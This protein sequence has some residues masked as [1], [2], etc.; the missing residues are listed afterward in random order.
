[1]KKIVCRYR[2]S[3]HSLTLENLVKIGCLKVTEVHSLLTNYKKV[4]Y[5]N[6]K[7]HY[8]GISSVTEGRKRDNFIIN[9]SNHESNIY[10]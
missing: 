2:V 4:Q 6:P 5:I 3:F 8:V 7:M 9:I 10:R 1:M